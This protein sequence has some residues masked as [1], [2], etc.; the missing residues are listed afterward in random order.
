MGDRNLKVV[1]LTEY[2]SAMSSVSNFLT[3]SYINVR[4]NKT[5]IK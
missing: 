1:Y 5:P 3:G 2:E 4:N